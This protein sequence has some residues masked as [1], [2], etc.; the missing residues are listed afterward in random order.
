MVGCHWTE[1]FHQLRIHWFVGS[2]SGEDLCKECVIKKMSEASVPLSPLD[3]MFLPKPFSFLA[4]HFAEQVSLQLPCIRNVRPVRGV[5][6][7]RTGQ[8]IFS[9]DKRTPWRPL[10]AVKYIRSSLAVDEFGATYWLRI[11]ARVLNCKRSDLMI[12]V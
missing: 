10:L 8:W 5:E 12:P 2:G 11:P 4:S 3:Q 7:E 1:N 9:G 6:I